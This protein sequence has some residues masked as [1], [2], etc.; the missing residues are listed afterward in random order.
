MYWGGGGYKKQEQASPPPRKLKTEQT[1]DSRGGN[2]AVVA[3][4]RE[5]QSSAEGGEKVTE[6]R[7]GVISPSLDKE[8]EG[9]S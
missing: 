5:G 7:S 4:E 9:N 8:T 3:Q 2:P 1:W 6:G